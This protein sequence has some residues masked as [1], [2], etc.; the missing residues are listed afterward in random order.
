M[1]QHILRQAT[2][3][4]CCPRIH[5]NGEFPTLP[6]AMKRSQ[7]TTKTISG[8]GFRLA[9]SIPTLRSFS[10]F[11][12]RTRGAFISPPE[13]RSSLDDRRRGRRSEGIVAKRVTT[14]QGWGCGFQ[15]VETNMN[16][17]IGEWATFRH[18]QMTTNT[19]KDDASETSN[20]LC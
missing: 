20:A 10:E 9:P 5:R 15:R 12:L 3:P 19:T 4:L 8:W 18:S 16:I 14:I 7:A 17:T 13:G 1:W 6:P 11:P 2:L